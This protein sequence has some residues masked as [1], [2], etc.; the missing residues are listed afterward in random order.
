MLG[1]KIWLSGRKT[2]ILLSNTF[3]LKEQIWVFDV[4]GTYPAHYLNRNGQQSLTRTVSQEKSKPDAV[5]RIEGY[6][7]EVNTNCNYLALLLSSSDFQGKF[8]V[9]KSSPRT[10]SGEPGED[11]RHPRSH[12][13]EMWGQS[14][15]PAN[16]H[17]KSRA[18]ELEST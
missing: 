16:H 1:A 3:S 10:T 5:G 6:K 17:C 4:T 8:Q 15:P 14:A 13:P 7:V 11:A 2:I 18:R 12:R 9:S